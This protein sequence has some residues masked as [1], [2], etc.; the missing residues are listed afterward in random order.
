MW[1]WLS[2]LDSVIVLAPLRIV[3]VCGWRGW[4][5]GGG[6]GG[7][8]GAR[9]CVGGGTVGVAPVGTVG[10]GG[11]GGCDPA[12]GWPGICGGWVGRGPLDCGVV[13]PGL[14]C[15]FPTVGG[16]VRRPP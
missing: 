15:P 12:G 6:S 14:L 16:G 9:G 7:G 2:G 1:P 8:V 4:E 10:T 11:R 13:D 3:A 5:G